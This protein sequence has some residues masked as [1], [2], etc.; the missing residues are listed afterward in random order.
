MA[1]SQDT[2]AQENSI[3]LDD[4]NDLIAVQQTETATK[5][6]E[7][8]SVNTNQA[9]M[10]RGVPQRRTFDSGYGEG[11]SCVSSPIAE[12]KKNGY[13]VNG[14]NISA[15]SANTSASLS[16]QRI[17]ARLRRQKAIDRG[18]CPSSAQSRS[19]PMSSSY[20]QQSYTANSS[21]DYEDNDYDDERSLYSRRSSSVGR[22]QEFSC[23]AYGRLRRKTSTTSSS[24]NINDDGEDIDDIE[25]RTSS[26][27]DEENDREKAHNIA[28]IKRKLKASLPTSSS[29][30][31]ST[32]ERKQKNNGPHHHH[33]HH[34]S[35]TTDKQQHTMITMNDEIGDLS[36]RI[37]S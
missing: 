26:S 30:R 3:A 27:D 31:R 32:M 18:S 4:C 12:P 34:H 35:I 11:Q 7:Q 19:R 1:D 5:P 2:T 16:G 14:G 36:P 23:H 37:I 17:R 33:H 13:N 28:I 9:P 6:N 20:H 22:I 25:G 29:G 24:D 8:D 10:I 15:S 21:T